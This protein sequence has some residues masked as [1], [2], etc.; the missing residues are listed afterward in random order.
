[1]E[2]AARI[3]KRCFHLTA[4]SQLHCKENPLYVFPEKELRGLSPT[5]NIHVSLSDLYIPR[6]GPHIFMQQNR[7][8]DPS[9]KYINRSQTHECAEIG[10]ETAQ[11]F[12]GNSFLEFS[13][14]CLCSVFV[15]NQYLG[16]MGTGGW[17]GGEEGGPGRVLRHVLH[18]SSFLFAT[19]KSVPSLKFLS[20]GFVPHAFHFCLSWGGGGGGG[21]KDV[22]KANFTSANTFFAFSTTFSLYILYKQK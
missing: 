1:M 22:V 13:V 17:G 11:S 16:K 2:W 9:Y 7:Q 12:S 5:F 14:L 19:N 6:I 20:L 8:T 4:H 21:D 3:S 15:L 10:T 18:L